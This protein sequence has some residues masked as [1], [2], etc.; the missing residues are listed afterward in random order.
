MVALRSQSLPVCVQRQV[1]AE[2]VQPQQAG[3][4]G[5]QKS[6]TQENWRQVSGGRTWF[7]CHLTGWRWWKCQ[8]HRDGTSGRVQTELHTAENNPPPQLKPIFVSVGTTF[9]IKL[10][11]R[12]AHSTHVRKNMHVCQGTVSRLGAHSSLQSQGKA[13]NCNGEIQSNKWSCCLHAVNI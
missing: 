2:Q 5:H 3:Y 11:T 6:L 1:S 4:E 10:L 7:S 8:S 12:S 13:G 9:D